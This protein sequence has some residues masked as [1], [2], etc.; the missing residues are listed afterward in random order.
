MVD[1]QRDIAIVG[2]SVYSPT[3]EGADNFW[4]GLARGGD[5]ITEVPYDVIESYHFT[6]EPNGIDRFYVNRGG[7]APPFKVDLLHFGILPIVADS[8][9]PDQIVALAGT[10]QALIDADVFEKNI[11]LN[12][13]SIIIGKGNFSGFVGQRIFEILRTSRQIEALMKVALPELTESDLIRIRESYQKMYGRYHADIATNTMPSLV[14]SLVANRFDMHGAAYTL[15]AACAS[16]ILAIEHAIH[17]LRSGEC[18]IA[19]TG[20]MHTAQSS[21]F[22]GPFDLLGAL[23]HQGQIAPFSK[24]ADGLLIGQGG[25]FI[26]LKT[27]RKAL[28]DE[29]RIY[30]IIK[31]TA[32]TSDG[33]GS[34][35]LVTSVAGELRVLKKAWERAGMDPKKVGYVEAHGTGTP[36]G[37]PVELTTLKE[38]FG[39]KSC[40]P[41]FVGSVKSNIGHTM[42]AAGTMGIIKTALAL[43]HRKIPATLHCEEPHPL[44]FESRFLPPQELIDWDEEQYPLVAG[45]NAFGFGGANSHA[46]LTPYEQ[47][48]GMPPQIRP[49]RQPSEACLLSA[50]TRDALLE[51]LRTGDFTNT[52]GTYRLVLFDPTDKRVETAISIVEKDKP[53]RGRMDIWFSNAPMLADGGKVIFLCSGFGPDEPAE[54][55]SIS[56]MLRLPSM[57]EL[58]A[59]EDQDEFS[60]MAFKYY[61]ITWLCKEGLKKLGVTPDFYGGNSTGEWTA[62]LFAGMID[63]NP[64]DI[65]RPMLS[66]VP[67][68]RSLISVIGIDTKTALQW[69]A[70]IPGLYLSNSN[71]PSQVL[72]T[73]TQDALDTLLKR[74]NA[75]HTLYSVLPYG[76]GL[77]TPLAQI[78]K[79]AYTDYLADINLQEGEVPVWSSSTL[80]IIPTD[81]KEYA[82]LLES[83]LTRPVYFR[84]LIEKLYDEQDVRVFVQ[85]G[86][87]PLIGFIKDTL[88][89]KDFGA[90]AGCVP[91]RESADQ[92]RRVLATLFIEGREVDARFL[93]VR[94][95]YYTATHGL[96]TLPRG[97]TPVLTEMP[98]LAKIVTARYGSAGPRASAFANTDAIGNSILTAASANMQK[99]VKTQNELVEFFGQILKSA[100]VDGARTARRTLPRQRATIDATAQATTQATDKATGVAATVPTTPKTFEEPIHLTFQDHPYVI[101][102]S[103]V[104][105]PRDWDHDED[106][107]VV[108]PLTMSI[109]LLAEIALKHAGGRKLLKVSKLNA[110]RWIEIEEPFDGIVRGT[111]KGADTLE[112]ELV[113]RLKCEFTFGEE[114][115]EPPAEY[116]GAI[117][118]GEKIM[119]SR[120]A[121]ELYDRYSFH[122][123]QYHS[124]I[125]LLGVC[126]RGIGNLA[127]RRA[128]K[129]SLLDIMGQQ[130][131]LFLHLTQPYNVASFP[132]RIKELTFYADIFDQEGEF[133]HTLVITKLTEYSV[134][135][136]MVLKRNG[137]IWSVARNW[138][139]Q[140]FESSKR[141]WNILIKPQI[142]ILT[143]EIAPGVHYFENKNQGNLLTLIGKRYLNYA[144]NATLTDA[145]SKQRREY[146]TSRI[147]LKDAVRSFVQRGS[148][149]LLYP[150]EVFCTHDENGKPSVYGRPG[151]GDNLKD[152][153]VSLAHKGDNA[154]AIAADHPV[155]IDLEKIEEKSEGFLAFTFTE[156]ER[157]LLASLKQPEGVT[158]FWVAKEACAKKAGTGL[159]GNPKNFEISA[160]DGDVLYVG[161]Q[162]VQTVSIGEEYLAG[163]TI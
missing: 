163:W 157:E 80:D 131:G 74:L 88:K 91:E 47:G 144:D 93:G 15:D 132:V 147:A 92:M 2:I 20:G 135:A 94:A 149:E 89:G 111:W 141:A 54:T 114:W 42:S 52:G 44:M 162:G 103:I 81:K 109:E 13:C 55:D 160:V 22:W 83:Q 7:F 59:K 112:L 27:L 161:N 35:P 51:K 143:D 133:E 73:G 66:V 12:R 117:D 53:W 153:Q 46:I 70:E 115:G 41:A 99:A 102:H 16:G 34:S 43:Y 97:A 23:S 67:E 127:K 24:N 136:D 39:D 128:G 152:V 113:G 69:C 86:V 156:R 122:G 49:R 45:V 125:S 32:V 8:V 142:T 134:T 96:T 146:L 36:A 116:A 50:R 25:G 138:V 150:I 105:Q 120:P 124:N 159:K 11:S 26:V 79:N 155:G 148:D 4:N 126:A 31:D 56:E 33:A 3:G 129:G 98:E 29:D 30:A 90:V 110:Y 38:F 130:I 6:G 82:E 17:H 140:R 75:I 40:P 119:E 9:E 145:S 57:T 14:A 28:E 78:P 87:G 58:L 76:T 85:L 137:K 62:T 118:I 151:V 95:L 100:H 61:Y 64:S 154:I 18:D 139:N 104:R 48:T 158:R 106:L 19:V 72:L 84:E 21:L 107:M 5:F 1:E 77:H 63:G 60:Q 37:D 65:Y 123:P 10:E 101:D 71:C 121:A 68:Y 108:I